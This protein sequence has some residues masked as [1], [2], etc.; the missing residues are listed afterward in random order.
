[1]SFFCF[2]LHNHLQEE[3]EIN[4]NNN[5]RAKGTSEKIWKKKRIAMASASQNDFFGNSQK[6][7]TKELSSSLQPENAVT[8]FDYTWC[9]LF[10]WCVERKSPFQAYVLNIF[11]NGE[12]KEP[13]IKGTL[14][15][16]SRMKKIKTFVKFPGM[17]LSL[18]A[19]IPKGDLYKYICIYNFSYYIFVTR[20]AN[21]DLFVLITFFRHDFG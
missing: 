18:F 10:D 1:M 9:I 2:Q 4:V 13:W 3:E 11:M 17:T 15:T 5:T 6:V 12:I 21:Y 16:K 7:T 20:R 14:G 19:K 8:D